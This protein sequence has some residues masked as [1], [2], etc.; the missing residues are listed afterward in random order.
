MSVIVGPLVSASQRMSS[1]WEVGAPH[2]M[3]SGLYTRRKVDRRVHRR[4]Y[5]QFEK[6]EGR[7]WAG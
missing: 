7:A 4:N 1:R 2:T 5:E 3:A 6:P